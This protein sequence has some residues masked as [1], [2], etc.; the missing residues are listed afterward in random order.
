MNNSELRL[1]IEELEEHCKKKI[2]LC[3]QWKSINAVNK[4]SNQEDNETDS[5]LTNL[6]HKIFP[7]L[8]KEGEDDFARKIT[9]LSTKSSNSLELYEKTRTLLNEIREKL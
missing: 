9:E 8:L 4:S 5:T 7:I 3:L 1:A 2:A 6:L